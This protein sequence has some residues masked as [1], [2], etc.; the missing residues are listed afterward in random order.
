MRLAIYKQ[1]STSL[2]NEAYIRNARMLNI[3][4][5]PV[6]VAEWLKKYST[7]LAITRP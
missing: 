7:C 3:K 1:D 5:Q 6:L 4:N 2:S